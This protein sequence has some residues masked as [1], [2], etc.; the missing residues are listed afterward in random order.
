[1]TLINAIDDKA[2]I[3]CETNDC[4]DEVI[5]IQYLKNSYSNPTLCGDYFVKFSEPIPWAWSKSFK[6]KEMPFK[7][8]KVSIA[9]D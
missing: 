4:F 1:M 3:N 9:C 7:L 2:W 8:T 5:P 6:E